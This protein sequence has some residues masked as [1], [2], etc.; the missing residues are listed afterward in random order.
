[1][2]N[3]EELVEFLGKD[4]QEWQLKAKQALE[5]VIMKGEIEGAR[6]RLAEFDEIIA[7]RAKRAGYD[8]IILRKMGTPEIVDLGPVVIEDSILPESK[9]A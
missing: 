8:G 7:K 5:D 1:M 9:A 3:R 4:D 6:S 2:G